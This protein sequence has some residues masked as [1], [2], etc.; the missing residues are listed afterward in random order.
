MNLNDTKA[1]Y[2]SIIPNAITLD[3]DF[4]VDVSIEIDDDELDA[5]TEAVDAH[6]KHKFEQLQKQNPENTTNEPLNPQQ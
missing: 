3:V 2:A 1:K 6:I 4:N 5:I